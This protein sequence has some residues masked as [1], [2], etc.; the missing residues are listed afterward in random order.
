[1]S[2]LSEA[3]EKYHLGWNKRTCFPCNPQAKEQELETWQRQVHDEA[4]A[5]DRK[6]L[7]LTESEELQQKRVLGE[8]RTVESQ[9]NDAHKE[10]LATR[11]AC[12]RLKLDS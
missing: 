3:A 10:L 8:F 12:D 11:A 2:C 4:A 9:L 7:A 6:Q 1:M 5:V